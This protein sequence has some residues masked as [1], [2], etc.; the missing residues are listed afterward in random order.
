MTRPIAKQDDLAGL[1]RAPVEPDADGLYRTLPETDELRAE[2]RAVQDFYDETGWQ[3]DEGGVF[4]DTALF[5]DPR[6]R[7]RRTWRVAA[8]A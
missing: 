2:K 6:P 1:L 3:Q 8:P 5:V 4:A 7:V